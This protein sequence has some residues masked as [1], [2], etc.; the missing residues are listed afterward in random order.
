ME[1]GVAAGEAGVAADEAGVAAEAMNE[2]I[3]S[4]LQSKLATQSVVDGMDS[5]TGDDEDAMVSG[6]KVRA[7]ESKKGA[8]DG[9]KAGSVSVRKSD[10]GKVRLDC[11]KIS[12][13]SAVDAEDEVEAVDAVDEVDSVEAVDAVEAVDEPSCA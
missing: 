11:E 7:V 5:K 1:A 8:P 3:N 12:E 4:L 6:H 9:I 10:D 13:E 2:D